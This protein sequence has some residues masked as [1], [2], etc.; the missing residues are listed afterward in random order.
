[1]LT[2]QS[3]MASKDTLNVAELI[4]RVGAYQAWQIVRGERE[5]ISWDR[6]PVWTPKDEADF[7]PSDMSTALV[8]S[9]KPLIDELA[10]PEK[11]NGIAVLNFAN[12]DI[13]E[14]ARTGFE[15]AIGQLADFHRQYQVGGISRRP[16]E[17]VFSQH[18]TFF[19]GF[20]HYMVYGFADRGKTEGFYRHHGYF[21]DE[22][23]PRLRVSVVNG[24][25]VVFAPRPQGPQPR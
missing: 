24:P 4:E 25:S 16:S 6:Y 18:P 7:H 19:S 8:T 5:K 20:L 15:E 9:L 23:N 1:M 12:P 3:V 14:R 2:S 13:L 11:G 10:L 17:Y 22:T 21:G